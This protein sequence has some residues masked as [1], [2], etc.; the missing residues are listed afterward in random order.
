MKNT[1]L[2]VIFLL[3]ICQ[4]ALAQQEGSIVNLKDME[5]P[6]SPAFML[7][8]V[9][10]TVIERPGTAKA[11]ALGIVNSVSKSAGL[12]QNYALEFTPFWFFRHPG[13]SSLKYHGYNVLKDRQTVFSNIPKGSVSMAIVQT[14]DSVSSFQNIS[15]GFRTNLV[16]LRRAPDI[17]ALIQANNELVNQLRDQQERLISFIGDLML[18]V[19]NP[20]LY[21]QKV[22][23]F[24]EQEEI[25]NRNKKNQIAAVIGR[26]PLL[27]VDVAAAMNIA[28]Q[29]QQYSTG[30]MGRAGVWLT[31]NYA[32]PIHSKDKIK[33][34][35]LN[36]YVL[37]RYLSDHSYSGPS[38]ESF[39]FGGK[40]ELEFECISLA[41]EYVL[42]NTDGGHT[43]R[44]SGEV[45]Y[46]LSEALYLSGAFGRNF[47]EEQNLIAL[48][49]LHWG[50]NTGNETIVPE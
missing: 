21:E 2:F 43:F 6:N 26:R 35:Y 4:H 46:R 27:S 31:A 36:L 48:F 33:E 20:V 41:Y 9:G 10:S 17:E 40:I 14:D 25:T 38:R 34:N 3:F 24:F 8:D 16:T 28:F 45:R 32:Q 13:M 15:F 30:K 22:R 29:D 12:P 44:S 50:I 37:A 47:G 19:N 7:L 18:R 23:E 5:V 49:G 42:R 39:D 11:F 1:P